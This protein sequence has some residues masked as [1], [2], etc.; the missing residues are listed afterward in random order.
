MNYVSGDT[1]KLG[2]LT[3]FARIKIP[4]TSISRVGNDDQKIIFLLI[5][6]QSSVF[7]LNSDFS[8]SAKGKLAFHFTNTDGTHDTYAV[9]QSLDLRDNQW[10]NVC[11]FQS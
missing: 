3:I 2:E 5:D 9:N 11:N 1:D 7:L 8:Q 10:H 4:T 6:Q